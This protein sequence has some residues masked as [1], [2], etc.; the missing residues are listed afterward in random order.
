MDNAQQVQSQN[1][2][3]MKWIYDS[4]ILH[5]KVRGV[6][7]LYVEMNDPLKLKKQKWLIFL[8][9]VWLVT[10]AKRG[11]YCMFSFILMF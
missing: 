5:I 3:I 1:H 2:E 9:V 10:L 8:V 4:Y 7:L 11:V 6:K